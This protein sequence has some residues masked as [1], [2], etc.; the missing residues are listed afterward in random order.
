MLIH[1]FS[2]ECADEDFKLRNAA[3][4]SLSFC[5]PPTDMEVEARTYE[6]NAV[7]RKQLELL[8]TEEEEDETIFDRNSS[9]D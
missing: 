7:Y 3:I 6:V 4:A 5:M 8:F 2:S 9:D 1:I